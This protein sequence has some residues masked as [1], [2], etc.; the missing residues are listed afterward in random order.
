MSPPS[1]TGTDALTPALIAPGAIMARS[2]HTPSSPTR[3][4]ELDQ[5]LPVTNDAT[6]HQNS[7]CTSAISDAV[8]SVMGELPA[9]SPPIQSG[10]IRHTQSSPVRSKDLYRHMPPLRAVDSSRSSLPEARSRERRS[11][12]IIIRKSG[13]SRLATKAKSNRPIS[14][15]S[16]LLASVS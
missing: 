12:K 9:I 6:A 14:A 8:N 11:C 16:G 5:L 4:T 13:A 2:T 7:K 15:K 10:T 1:G 3:L